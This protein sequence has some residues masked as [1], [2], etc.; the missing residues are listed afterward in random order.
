MDSEKKH[1]AGSP[2]TLE[3]NPGP[4]ERNGR[5]GTS[6]LKIGLLL[7]LVLLLLA[8]LLP[9]PASAKKSE[10]DHAEELETI[11]EMLRETLNL[12]R[13]GKKDEA[14]ETA[15]EAYLFHYELL[16]P[17][18]RAL[19]PDHVFE[20]EENFARLRSLIKNGEPYEDVESMVRKIEGGLDHD[21]KLLFKPGDTFG[22]VILLISFSIIFREGLEAA[23]IV[24]AI[25]GY[26][27]TS[28][29]YN[30]KKYIYWGSLLAV[31]A[32][33]ITWFVAG[34]LLSVSPFQQELIEAVFTLLA[35]V[36]LFYVSFWIIRKLEWKRW[37]EFVRAKVWE[38]MSTG[39]TL[40][41][42]FLAFSTVYREGFETVIFYRSLFFITEDLHFW[43]ITGFI[44]G[45]LAVLGISV[46]VYIFGMRVPSR[47]FMGA[48]M[49]I[50]SFLSVT[51]I[52][53]GVHELQEADVIGFTFLE[54]MPRLNP[55]VAEFTGI[56]RTLET[57]LAQIVLASIYVI[58]AIYMFV[59]RPRLA[60]GKG[61]AGN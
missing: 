51:F 7:L 22:T 5:A 36:V 33:I 16:E 49:G 13:E 15:K 40:I 3:R 47:Y 55:F 38:A 6:K 53:N 20:T 58:G 59:V 29:N 27:E 14:Y 54:W 52:G 18:L 32:S 23:I 26:L 45:S 10:V 46:A 44:L 9:E 4:D 8:S 56:H 48:T 35:V 1:G 43:V 11:R 34:Y 37:R 2:P 61:A 31:I 42:V 28:K 12:Y 19:D 24:G 21:E 30:L 39:N 57:L 17:P 60:K 41:L 50:A 25:L